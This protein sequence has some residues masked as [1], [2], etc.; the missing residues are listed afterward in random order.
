[1]I[2]LSLPDSIAW[3][4]QQDHSALAAFIGLTILAS[5]Y[6]AS[7]YSISR[8]EQ[9]RL[10]YIMLTLERYAAA[11]ATLIT[12][13][14][15]ARVPDTEHKELNERLLACRT[16]P[17]ATDNVLSLIN[18]FI[19]DG[20]EARLPLLLRTIERESE[21]LIAERNRLLELRERPGWGSWI[22]RVCRPLLPALC[23]FVLGGLLLGS[24]GLLHTSF[25]GGSDTESI[26]F[27]WIRL[28]SAGLALL[29]IFLATS[30]GPNR[31]PR[32]FSMRLL[33]LITGL[34]ALLHLAG[35]W[36][37]PYILGLQ[38]LLLLGGFRLNGRK[39]RKARPYAGQ[40]DPAAP[41]TLVQDAET[42]S[43]MIS[44]DD[45]VQ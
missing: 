29:L 40:A 17:Y 11:S 4:H 14:Q 7:R 5:L 15:Q 8:N 24:L 41:D 9:L 37:A 3:L 39:P 22:W 23:A 12:A 18:A 21:Q 38:G 33:A 30:G 35:L 26:V 20:D 45:Q 42:I 1:M 19:A 13:L 28:I 34:L 6:G 32:A 43:L 31:H 25:S 27:S 36:L 10:E 16:A 2:I 44:E